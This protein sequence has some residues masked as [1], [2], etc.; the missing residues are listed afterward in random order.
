MVGWSLLGLKGSI[1]GDAKAN[2][3]CLDSRRRRSTAM[4]EA[5]D[6][7]CE[8]LVFL[9][10]IEVNIILVGLRSAFVS[11]CSMGALERADLLGPQTARSLF[12]CVEA[13]GLLGCRAPQ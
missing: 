4:E 13:N 1:L 2:E 3:G 12:R 8:D 11:S 7:W 5:V 6:R 9:I 10:G